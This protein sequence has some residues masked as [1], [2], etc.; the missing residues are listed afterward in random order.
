MNRLFND[1]LFFV[2]AVKYDFFQMNELVIASQ[3]IHKVQEIRQ[4]LPSSLKLK[5]LNEL[6]FHE[7]IPETGE[8]LEENAL[9]KAKRIFDEFGLPCIA[10]DTGLEVDALEGRPGV[11]SARYAGEPANARNNMEKVLKEM[12]GKLLRTATFRTV[13]VLLDGNEPKYFEGAV[14]GKISRVPSGEGG[15][16]YDPIF[17]PEC[18][19]QSFSE[20]L[21]EEKNRISHRGRALE[22]LKEY[23]QNDK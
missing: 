3:N 16:G 21:P 6:D 2:P 15:F 7:E 11:Y 5:D 9:I 22:K 18:F 4:M 23:F 8:T 13:I 14:K 19:N 1:F 10:D 12:E 17:Y 20:M